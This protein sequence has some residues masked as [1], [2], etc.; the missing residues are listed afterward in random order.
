MN[1]LL[2]GI[3]GIGLTIQFAGPAGGRLSV[4]DLFI[5]VA[6]AIGVAARTITPSWAVLSRL[7]LLQCCLALSLYLSTLVGGSFSVTAILTRTAA[8][9]LFLPY[10]ILGGC[11]RKTEMI[12][13]IEGAVIGAGLP[14]LLFLL[15]EFGFELINVQSEGRLSGFMLDPNAYG[16]TCTA[17]L[18]LSL[19]SKQFASGRA[20]QVLAI[21][22]ALCALG[23]VLSLSRSAY[24]ASI[25]VLGLCHRDLVM[26][27]LRRVGGMLRWAMLGVL[28]ITAVIVLYPIYIGP[29]MS[30]RPGS[31]RADLAQS[32]TAVFEE[33]PLFG[34]GPGSSRKEATGEVADSHNS[35]L[36]V[37]AE[38]G[39]LGLL[40]FVFF[41]WPRR[42]RL[43]SE[44]QAVGLLVVF[45][46]GA[47]GIDALAQRLWWIGLGQ[48][49]EPGGD[50]DDELHPVG[51][52]TGALLV[53]RDRPTVR[54]S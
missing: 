9:I 5:V 21:G 40:P 44:H 13:L 43:A 7:V 29:V 3:I 25:V 2:Q 48:N 51:P 38:S 12:A 27:Q 37:A 26:N 11:W 19:A 49:D 20:R 53:E 30:A 16:L 33:S 50:G 34:S 39:L 46:T 6:L 31:G 22:G 52:A 8:P 15:G 23:V 24:I 32:A 36:V 47:L 28:L 14:V 45:A 18:S 1:R 10:L 4:S 41:V 17:L 54:F 42:P 35:Y